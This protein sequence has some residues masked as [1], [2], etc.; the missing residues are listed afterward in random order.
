MANPSR[1]PEEPSV[2]DHKYDP[3]VLHVHGQRFP[4]D[5][6][7]IYGTTTGLER[8][9][10]ALIDG[11][12]LGHGKCN[13][14]VRDGFDANLRVACLDGP[15]REEDWRRSGSPYFDIEDPLVARIME[16]TEEN[17]RLRQSIA[18][19]KSGKTAGKG[20]TG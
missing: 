2:S 5:A 16:L 8:L 11:V 10:S 18:L 4:S 13:F 17:A 1:F 20:A 9:I 3:P 19:L 7:E 6:V 15:R 12:N 14:V